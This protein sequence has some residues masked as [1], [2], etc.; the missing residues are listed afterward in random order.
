[1]LHGG[2]APVIL[3]RVFLWKNDVVD[4]IIYNEMKFT[5]GGM[6]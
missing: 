4:D 2:N 3:G 5:N 6:N 1:M